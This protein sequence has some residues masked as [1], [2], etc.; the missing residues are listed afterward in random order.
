[1]NLSIDLFGGTGFVGSNFYKLFKDEVYVHPRNHNV[2]YYKNILYMISTTDNYNVLE[3]P[4][5]DINTNLIK[6]IDVLDNCKNKDVIFNFISSWFVYGDTDLPAKETSYCNPKGFYSITKKCAEDLLISYCKTFNIK[7]RIL[8]LANVYGNN[9]NGISKKKNA[10][11]YLINRIKNHEEINLYFNGNFIR[12]YIHVEDACKAIKLCLEKGQVNDIYNI[13]NGEPI[14]FKNIIDYVV[15]KTNSK[16]IINAIDQP[17]F[18][19]I[20]QVK[21]MYLNIEK[22]K[23]LGF[24]PEYNIF[25][26][27]SDLIKC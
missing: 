14:I 2:P 20:V 26:G 25:T 9:D 11:T 4:Y 24:N 18:H 23:Y 21:N 19:K 17:E 1:M 15:E 22:I 10:L 6:L 8:R 12:D 5:K 16:S 3:D 13:G 7:Y 27:L